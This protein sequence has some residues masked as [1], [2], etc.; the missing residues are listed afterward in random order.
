[1][2][3]R[4]PLAMQHN[5]VENRFCPTGIRL[6]KSFVSL[7]LK[8]IDMINKIFY[9]LVC[10]TDSLQPNGM[11]QIQ[12]EAHLH[13]KSS[14]FATNIFVKPG[15]WD[16]RRQEIKKHPNAEGLNRMLD[17]YVMDLERIELDLWQQR[18]VVSLDLLRKAMDEPA[19]VG[20]FLP[21]MQAE[22]EA[23]SLRPSTRRNHRS[24]LLQLQAFQDDIA[25]DD[26]TFEFITRFE[27][28][29]MLQGLHINTVAKH[30]K[31]LKRY[32][33]VAINKEYIGI[34][35]YPF[36]KYRIKTVSG[37]HTHLLP[38]ELKRLERLQ[39]QGRHVRHGLALDAFLF[40]C[41]TGLRYSDFT[42]LSSRNLVVQRRRRWLIYTSVKTGTEVRLPLSELFGGKAQEILQ[43]HDKHL[44]SFFRLKDN[45]NLNKELRILAR[46]AG[47]SKRLSFHVAR[48]TNAT[49]LIYKGVN[50]TTVQRLLGHRSIKTTQIYAEVMD[51]TLLQELAK[52]KNGL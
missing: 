21:F 11:T 22:I 20:A 7:I 29:L 33:N 10:D 50:L 27:H 40:C 14:L 42:S 25:F 45:S 1:M 28:F 2:G 6:R 19:C 35:Q 36:R 13:K 23:L 26:L 37:R 41:Y 32:I 30:L 18:K 5:D 12:I 34:N 43:R 8:P 4:Q 17:S 51:R 39:L 9:T 47:I 49:L 46:M 31:H 15:Q 48:H 44:D 52:T 16:A 38:E 3:R 24:T